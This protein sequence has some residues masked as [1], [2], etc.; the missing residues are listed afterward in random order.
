MSDLI[1]AW[2]IDDIKY[3]RFYLCAFYFKKIVKLVGS[4]GDSLV[5]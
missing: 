5:V 4:I 2:I 1:F 3:V